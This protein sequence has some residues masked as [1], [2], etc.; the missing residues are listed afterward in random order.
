MKLLLAIILIGVIALIG[1]RLTFFSRRLTLGF[2][3]IIFT[4]TE[5]IFLG[6]FLGSRGLNILDP[7]TLKQFEPFLLFGLGWIGFLFGIQ[8]EVRRMRFLPRRYFSITAIQAAVVFVLV[9]AVSWAGLAAFDLLPPGYSLFAAVIL[10]SAASC[11]AQSAI[12]IVN[13][14]FRIENKGLLGL[15][16]Y[17]SSVDGLFALVFFGL[18][19]FFSSLRRCG[20][21][22]FYQIRGVAGSV[23]VHGGPAR[24]DS[25]LFKPDTV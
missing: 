4:G 14:N 16:R 10:G 9:S 24:P 11:T 19:F 2:K 17:I 18:S 25:D 1:S 23:A 3:N 6:F 12:A 7:L 20:R 8:F 5:Y 13:H 22:R 21:I 15:M